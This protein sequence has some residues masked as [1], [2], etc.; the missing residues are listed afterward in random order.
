MNMHDNLK[1]YKTRIIK[2][3]KNNLKGFTKLIFNNLYCGK[4]SQLIYKIYE[5]DLNDK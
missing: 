1:H 5:F 4:V 3:K 2:K